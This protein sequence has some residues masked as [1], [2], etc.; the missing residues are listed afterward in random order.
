[1]RW[2]RA[3]SKRCHCC[4]WLNASS[5]MANRLSLQNCSLTLCPVQLC[6]VCNRLLPTLEPGS[7]AVRTPQNVGQPTPVVQPRLIPSQLLCG[8]K[9]VSSSPAI[10]I[11]SLCI[12]KTGISSTR[13]VFPVCSPVMPTPYCNFAFWSV[14]DRTMSLC[15]AFSENSLECPLLGSA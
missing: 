5:T 9:C 10:P 3:I 12:N 7:S 2:L 14:F 13:S 4:V 6:R 11:L 1:M 15:Y 8:L